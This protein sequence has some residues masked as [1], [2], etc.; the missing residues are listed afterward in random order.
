MF[1]KIVALILSLG[2]VACALLAVR[3]GRIQAFHELTQTRLRIKR[4]DEQILLL[5]TRIASLVTPEHV[6]EM[7]ASARSLKPIFD[8]PLPAPG[9]TVYDDLGRTLTD[10]EAPSPGQQGSGGRAT[11]R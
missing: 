3:Q 5:R 10:G 1:A 2:I 7:A 11:H 9:R 4:Q 6:H 8:A